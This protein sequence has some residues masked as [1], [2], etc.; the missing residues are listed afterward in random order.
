MILALS[1]PLGAGK[2]TLLQKL[3]EAY[4]VRDVPKSP[5]FSLV[6]TYAIRHSSFAIRQLVHV[7]AYRIERP[8]DVRTLGLD[9]LLVEPGT[10]MAI[11]WPENIATWLKTRKEPLMALSIGLRRDGRRAVTV[12]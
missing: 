3:A 7:D 12:S 2:T 11:E 8:E 5:T 9:E 10:V 4:G 1:G 6:R